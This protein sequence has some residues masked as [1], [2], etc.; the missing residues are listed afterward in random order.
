MN[1]IAVDTAPL[2]LDALQS[3]LQ[4]VVP[5]AE[6][7]GFQNAAKALQYMRAH[8]C[9]IVFLAVKMQGTSGLELAEKI[10]ELD[11]TINIVFLTAYQE[12]AIDA[13]QLCAS[14]Y[15]LKPVD[16]KQIRHA[17]A[18]LRNPVTT[19]YQKKIRLQCFGNFEAFHDKVPLLF[20][21]GKAKEVLAYLTDRKGA[22]C[23]MGQLIGI[24]WEDGCDTVS[25]RSNLRNI[26]SDLR[27]VLAAAGAED[28]IRKHHNIISLNCE[29][30][31]CD[32]FDYLEGDPAA[33]NSY[34]GEYMLQ[35]SWAETTNAH[36]HT[37]P[38]N[39]DFNRE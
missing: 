12:Y 24:L 30:V 36:F 28:I 3:V 2:A 25:R 5:D 35:Y 1:V 33:V 8:H 37:N 27:R 19:E 6:F 4:E 7:T 39:A 22:E 31:E 10:R 13:F 23:T 16:E 21:R 26:I 20:K 34:N 18:Q 32:Y 17:L 38:D 9:D 15:L 14:D 11:H 29:L